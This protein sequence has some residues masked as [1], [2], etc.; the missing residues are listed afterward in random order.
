MYD[1]ATRARAR[2]LRAEEGMPFKRIASSVGISVATAHAWAKDIQ[3]TDEQR[4]HNLAHMTPK[5]EVVMKRAATWRAINRRR[6]LSYQQ[7]GREMARTGDAVHQAGCMLYWAEGGKERNSMVFCNSDLNMVCFF[8]GFLVRCFSV[9]PSSFSVRLNV[10][11]GNGLSVREIEDRW[12]RTLGLPRSCLRKHS[13]NHFP[14]SSSGRRTNR[15]PYGVCTLR[16]NDTR[17]IQHIYGA[18]Q[19]YGGFDEPRWLDCAPRRSAESGA[20]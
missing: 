18:I 12:L 1:D 16:L 15:L 14:T 7:E 2:Q 3:I 9:E 5:S 20:S 11:T 4:Q 13:V 8:C 10:Y 6:R 19:E 17:I